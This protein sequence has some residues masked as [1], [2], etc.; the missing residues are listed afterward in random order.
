[1]RW[2][3]CPL[4]RR[5]FTTCCRFGTAAAIVSA[6]VLVVWQFPAEMEQ[7]NDYLECGVVEAITQR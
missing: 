4:S 1:M 3:F 5:S 6:C 7:I 2:P